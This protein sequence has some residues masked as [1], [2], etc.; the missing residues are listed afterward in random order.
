MIFSLVHAAH[1]AAA[2]AALALFVWRG[3]RMW[4]HNPARALLW[5]RILPDTIDTLLLLTGG[6]MIVMLG[7]YP[8]QSAWITAKLGA[9]LAYIALGFVAFRGAGGA[10]SRAAWLAALLIFAYIVAVAHSKAAWPLA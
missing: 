1:E 9:V 2:L 8:L 7:V 3:W 4:R 6:T 10:L 5:R